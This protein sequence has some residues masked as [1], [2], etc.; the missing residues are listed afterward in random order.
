MLPF[1]GKSREVITK[2]LP[3]KQYEIEQS[4]MLDEQ[5]TADAIAVRQI[6]EQGGINHES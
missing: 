3:D 2:W 5:E 6:K 4:L 1:I